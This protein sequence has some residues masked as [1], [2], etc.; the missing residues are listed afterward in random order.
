MKKI[1]FALAAMLTGTLS[2]QAIDDTT[3]EIV[4][5]G[6]TATITVASNISNY[7]TVNSGTSSHVSITQSSSFDPDNF[8]TTDNTTGDI[9]YILSGTTTDGEFY[10]TAPAKATVSLEGV[11]LTNATPTYSGAAI[12]VTGG[13][14]I[15]LSASK[16]TESTLQD[17]A[18][19][20]QGA[21][22]YVK[23]HL[24]IQG[25]GTLN[26]YG[27]C[28]HAIKST[29]YMSLKNLTLNIQSAV[30]D[31]LHCDEYFLMTAGTLNL[32]NVTDDGIQ[33]EMD[34]E[35]S[36]G[37]TTDHEDENSGN[38][39]QTDGT[40]AATTVGG[41]VIKA[42]GSITNSGGTW[43]GFTS[44]N[45]LENASTGIEAI[46]I[47]SASTSGNVQMYD[48]S[49][50]PVSSTTKGIVIVNNNGKMQKMIVK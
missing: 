45:C 47:N 9:S 27:N 33:V 43:T 8:I 4:Y 14:R 50:R 11:T 34:A 36:T 6:T 5:S 26:V 13:K 39:Y 49:G 18:S 20:S 30:K 21:C 31:G 41:Y 1:L 48:L 29:E 2:V 12:F 38:F 46:R 15:K 28:K 19:G 25:R 10:L 32:I 3:V 22:V 16:E 40:I 37:Q 35:T 17:A 42:D 7:V 44:D 24:E 23:G